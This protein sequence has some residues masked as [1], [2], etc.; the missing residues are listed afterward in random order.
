MQ[1]RTQKVEVEACSLGHRLFV[2]F[3]WEDLV[4]KFRLEFLVLVAIPDED[5]CVH[6]IYVFLFVV[7]LRGF[8]ELGGWFPALG[9]QY[10]VAHRTIKPSKLTNYMNLNRLR[11][12]HLSAIKVR[13]AQLRAHTE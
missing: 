4:E 1:G 2:E 9:L 10:V 7:L 11:Y 3:V 13:Q 5:F 12:T 8:V 6:A